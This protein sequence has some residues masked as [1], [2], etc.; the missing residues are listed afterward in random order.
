MK[1]NES[2]LFA[3]K[4]LAV[5]RSPEARVPALRSV[6]TSSRALRLFRECSLCAQRVREIDALNLGSAT[7]DT[8]RGCSRS[9]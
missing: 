3:I 8:A 1:A 2:S 7:E 6:L 5:R 4:D 9:S